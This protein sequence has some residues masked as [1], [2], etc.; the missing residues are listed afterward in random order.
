MVY[1]STLGFFYII[2]KLKLSKIIYRLLKIHN[3]VF[4]WFL[5]YIF[6][7]SYSHIRFIPLYKFMEHISA[8]IRLLAQVFLYYLPQH[9]LLCLIEWVFIRPINLLIF[10]ILFLGFFILL[11]VKF[12]GLHQHISYKSELLLFALLS[13]YLVHCFTL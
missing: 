2:V 12:V 7:V 10:R 9:F 3:K 8:S 13:V 5:R 11:Q 6:N 4:F 1:Y